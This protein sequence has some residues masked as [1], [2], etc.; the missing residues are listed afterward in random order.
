M[1]LRKISFNKNLYVIWAEKYKPYEFGSLLYNNDIEVKLKKL[2]SNDDF[3][4]L[5]F[6]GPNGAGKRTLAKC[7]LSEL[8]GEGALKMKSEIKEFEA[9]ASTTVE[10]VVYSSTYHV[11]ISPSETDRYDRV[12]VNSIIKELAGT[13]SLNVDSDR[14]FDWKIIVIHDLDKLS[15]EAQSGLRRTMEKY[16]ANCRIIF[17]CESL[18]KVMAPLKSR[19]VQIRVPA[20]KLDD[21]ENTLQNIAKFEGFSLNDELAHKIAVNCKG[22]MRKGIMILQGLKANSTSLTASTKVLKPGY[23][24]TISEIADDIVR[25]QTPKQLK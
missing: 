4:H 1:Q 11:E 12:V 15:K 16:M 8:F 24:D 6:Y 25:E 18:S 14:K 7:I 2:I 21:I 23:E 3:P 22:N 13:A 9:T 5:L 19:W 17:N 20:P 10:W